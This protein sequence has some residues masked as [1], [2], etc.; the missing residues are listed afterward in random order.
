MQFGENGFR[1]PLEFLDG[2]FQ[3]QFRFFDHGINDIALV[4]GFHFP[5]EK[6]P[7]TGKMFF[8]SGARFDGSAAWR[9][10]IEHRNFQ[11]AIERERKRARNRRG[12]EHENMRSVAMAGG[13]VHQSLAL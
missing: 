13:L 1:Q 10:F 12:G 8:R 5:A 6:F 7:H 4:A 3:L 11:V 9:Q 2:R